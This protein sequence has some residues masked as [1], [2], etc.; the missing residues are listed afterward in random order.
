MNRRET[1]RIAQYL[2]D[3]K[4]QKAAPHA[5]ENADWS[6]ASD[7]TSGARD[8]MRIRRTIE[9]LLSKQHNEEELK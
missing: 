9:A 6:D 2:V 1:D 7:D 5:Q 8:W 4:G 3:Q